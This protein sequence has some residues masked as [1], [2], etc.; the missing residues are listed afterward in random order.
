MLCSMTKT[1]KFYGAKNKLSHYDKETQHLMLTAMN[2]DVVAH[3][4]FSL[5]EIVF[6]LRRSFKE[7]LTHKQ[8]LE[9]KTMRPGTDPSS[10]F[11]MIASYLIYSLTGGDKIWEM[12]GTN[13]HWWLYHKQSGAIF[14]V[15]HTQFSAQDIKEIYKLG[16][17]VSK[18]N[19]DNTF[20][21][22]L[23]IRANKLAHCAGI[24]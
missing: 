21:E 22:M 17:P 5:P 6:L 3:E 23:K 24:E 13:L 16:C 8:V 14:D 10:G 2:F 15:T 7:R 9:E 4:N 20:N 19:T 12:H 11:C 1:E 18:L